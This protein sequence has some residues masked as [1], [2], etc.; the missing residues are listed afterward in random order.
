MNLKYV[1][2]LLSTGT[3]I[4]AFALSTSLDYQIHIPFYRARIYN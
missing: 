2:E 1:K 3:E 4:T